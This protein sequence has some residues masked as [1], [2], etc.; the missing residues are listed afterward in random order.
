MLAVL[1]DSGELKGGEAGGGFVAGGEGALA[2]VPVVG[3]FDGAGDP[4][5][6]PETSEAVVE[7]G[8]LFL[9]EGLAGRV[10]GDADGDLFVGQFA[11]TGG[12]GVIVALVGLIEVGARDR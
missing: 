4:S 11:A 9:D 6:Q 1:S 10:V 12:Q 5:G 3:D 8:D 7:G 2:G